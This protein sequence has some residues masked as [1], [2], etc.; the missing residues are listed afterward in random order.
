MSEL[1]VRVGPPQESNVQKMNFTSENSVL[2][3]Q[4]IIIEEFDLDGIG[5]SNKE[6][7]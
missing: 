5:H 1:A 2:V 4:N 6:E 7:H 3:S